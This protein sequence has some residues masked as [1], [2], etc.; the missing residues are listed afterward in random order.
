MPKSAKFY[1]YGVIAIGIAWFGGALMT[2]PSPWTSTWLAYLLLAMLA[3]GIK[4]RLPGLTGTY[5]LNFLFLLYGVV[6]FSLPEV[7]VAGCA[8]ALVQ[9]LFNIQKRPTRL[10]ILFNM[11]NLI[12]SSGACFLV[13]R[14]WL[15]AGIEHYRPA[16]LAL[17]A[18]VYFVVNTMLV[19]GVLAL[20]EGKRLLE[21]S[22]SWY[23]WSFPYY[24]IGTVVVGL[25]PISGYTTPGEAWL[26]LL[27]LAYLI[28]FFMG[29]LQ[30]RPA[31]G[32][33]K[34]SEALP[35][36]ARWYVIAVQGAGVLL[37]IW[38]A[39][40]WHSQDI[41][42]FVVYLVLS[43][44]AATLKI[45]LP[46]MRGT[47]SVGFV[48]RLVALAELSFAEALF[49]SAL[50]AIVQCV[51]KP[52]K[53][54]TFKRIFF[55]ASCLALSTAAGFVLCRVALDPWLSQSL[56][57][58]LV[59]ATLILYSTNTLIVSLVLCL[60]EH[61]PIRNVFQACY[62]WS[63]PYYLV[64]AAAA[65]LMVATSQVAGWQLSLLVLPVM[66]L[67]YVSYRMHLAPESAVWGA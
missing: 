38:A 46:G 5:S 64:G 1:V 48:L 59:L 19:S 3:S 55:N 12:L 27:P 28:H 45:Y 47:L 21:V 22:E 40:E 37:L 65:G 34:R 20:L 10:Q 30:S 2:W 62:F 52:K 31:S 44:I 54:P 58:F 9:S 42:R 16:L 53:T 32:E 26:L 41:V 14:V 67:V 56:I 18:F 63:C 35:S 24:L 61:K 15:P 23:A 66:S 49:L 39:I 51:W 36:A 60:V 17:I 43:V 33:V 57:A 8:G 29:L 25:V 11:A 4:L 7:L 6:R 13:A 50:A